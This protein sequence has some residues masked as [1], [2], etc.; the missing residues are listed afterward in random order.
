MFVSIGVSRATG[1]MMLSL[2]L[3]V[4]VVVA[5][6]VTTKVGSLI[7]HYLIVV[8]SCGFSCHHLKKKLRRMIPLHVDVWFIGSFHW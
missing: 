1:K 3:G 2:L 5:L 4:L 7:V 6:S 8:C